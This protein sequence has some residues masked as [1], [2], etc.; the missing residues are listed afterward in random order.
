METVRRKMR[1]QGFGGSGNFSET[2][3]AT[4]GVHSAAKYSGSYGIIA[5]TFV[6]VRDHRFLTSGK[7]FR[8]HE[9]QKRRPKRQPFVG[10]CFGIK[11]NFTILRILVYI[12]INFTICTHILF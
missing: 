3:A 4:F 7:A 10:Y 9:V 1:V 12:E 8:V 5:R 11:Y 2:R 6:T